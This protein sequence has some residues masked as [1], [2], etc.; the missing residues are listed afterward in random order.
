MPPL[1]LSPLSFLIC[2]S[3][4]PSCNGSSV[5]SAAFPRLVKTCAHAEVKPHDNKNMCHISQELIVGPLPLIVIR[6]LKITP[7][8]LFSTF[9]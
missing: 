4:Q 3:M 2:P 9:H 6:P 5:E 7:K 8:Q 1:S